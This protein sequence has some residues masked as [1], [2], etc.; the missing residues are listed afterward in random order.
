MQI[1]HVVGARPNFMKIAPV[2]RA[3]RAHE[4]VHSRLVHTGQHY[5]KSLSDVLFEDLSLP[6]P[7]A[8]LRVGSGS[9]ATQTANLLIRLEQEFLET[10]PDCIVV[11][12]DVNSTLAATLV[13]AK[14]H[15]R[16]VHV[17][18]GLRSGDR[19]MPEEVNR[20]VTDQLSDLLFTHSRSADD[21]LRREGVPD[22]R[23]RFV[24]NVIIDALDAVRPRVQRTKAAEARGLKPGGYGL[25]T[26]HRPSNVDDPEQLAEILAALD[27][28]AC[29]LPL[30]LPAHPRTRQRF[31]DFGA[32]LERVEVVDPVGYIEM[33][34]LQSTAALVLTDSGGIQEETTVLGVPCLTLRGTTER[35]LTIE[36]GTNVLVPVRSRAAILEAY[37]AVRGRRYEPMR[38]EGWDGAAAVRL[39]DE[40]VEWLGREGVP[41]S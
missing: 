39:A 34:S 27:E 6:S 8:N 9:H 30:L 7:D 2:L 40:L 38:P 12:G 3:L 16:V 35:P 4:G 24:G 18:A 5:D 1:T 14:L 41:R 19:R 29:D 13:A 15:M 32:R 10:R 36:C 33:Q 17:E 21:N 25:V 22:D 31:E 37:R 23:I 20:L 28:I 11:V 26:L